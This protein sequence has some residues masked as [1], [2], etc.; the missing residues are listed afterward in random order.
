MGIGT[1]AL[2]WFKRQFSFRVWYSKQILQQN[3]MLSG[4]VLVFF[5]AWF[6]CTDNNID[7]DGPESWLWRLACT[8]LADL[9]NPLTTHAR[10]KPSLLELNQEKPLPAGLVNRKYQLLFPVVRLKPK[11]IHAPRNEPFAS[12]S[13]FG[14]AFPN[15]IATS[16]WGTRCSRLAKIN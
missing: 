13:S 14:M 3:H 9:G 5:Y 4:K 12:G 7:F 10:E 15:S 16:E 1:S 8:H 6:P 11:D 2:T